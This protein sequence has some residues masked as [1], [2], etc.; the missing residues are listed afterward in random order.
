MGSS[1]ADVV[2]AAMDTQGE[3]AS[4]IDAIP[5]HPILGF[6]GARPWSGLEASA[7]GHGRG[8]RVG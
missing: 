5:T 7:I 8:A 3:A 4:V 6:I 1:N 2:E